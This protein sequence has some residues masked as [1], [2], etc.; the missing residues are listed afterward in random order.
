MTWLRIQLGLATGLGSGYLPAAP[1][2]CGT[3]VGLGLAWLCHP[4]SLGL[5]GVTTLGVIG[6]A[7]FSTNQVLPHFG[8][9]DPPQVVIDEVA[10]M[11]IVMAGHE[12]RATT[13]VAG[14]LAFRFFD[15][16]KPWP[17][18]A[19][20]SLPG[21][22]GVVADDCVAALYAWIVVWVAGRMLV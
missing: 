13:V 20:E 11:L 22:L 16:L 17:I 5:Y 1:G 14:F 3:L 21:G 18:R 2:T 7:I 15:I 12:W 19:A 4:L 9:G 10:A 8:T 6:I